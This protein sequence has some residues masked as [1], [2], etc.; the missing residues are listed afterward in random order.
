MAASSAMRLSVALAALL[1]GCSGSNFDV[2]PTVDDGAT[3]GDTAVEET[4]P[5]EDAI[6][7]TDESD[8]NPGDATIPDSAAVD[9]GGGTIDAVVEVSGEMCS[10][11]LSC[12]VSSGDYCKFAHCG[13]LSGT[14]TAIGP[15]SKVYAPVCGCDG[16]TYWSASFA[17][18][19]GVS[20]AH[21]EPCLAPEGVACNIDSECG[22]SGLCVH[23][24]SGA[25]GASCASV[26]KGRCW[27]KPS[28]TDC[29]ATTLASGGSVQTC[30]GE[31]K[32]RC[33]AIKDHSNFRN[34]ICS[35]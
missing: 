30:A 19:L 20:L 3:T 10:K 22:G 28:E 26:G 32:T 24:I 6:A 34:T 35:P 2:A 16:V 21:D 14:C 17:A 1:L 11:M 12:K 18:S 9:G 23:D 13:D 15:V 7:D 5:V 29:G 27:K 8:T 25:S 33:Q 4:S 31:C